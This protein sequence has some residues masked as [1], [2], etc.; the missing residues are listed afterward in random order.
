[1][2]RFGGR[3]ALVVGMSGQAEEGV[4][5]EFLA[6]SFEIHRRIPKAERVVAPR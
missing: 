2:P 3:G 1:V 6:D 4:V 5:Y